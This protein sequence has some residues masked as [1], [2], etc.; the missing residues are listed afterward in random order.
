MRINIIKTAKYDLYAIP[1]LKFH[2]LE[3]KR[4]GEY[5]ISLTG[6]YRLIITNDGEFFSRIEQGIVAES[7]EYGINKM[8]YVGFNSDFNK[9][10]AIDE[11]R[12]WHFLEIAHVRDFEPAFR[13]SNYKEPLRKRNL[14]NSKEIRS[15]NSR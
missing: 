9:E 3:G 15:I 5:A 4:K 1:T 10:Y 11:R 2:P 6:F 13:V 14:L 7:M 12:F 8:F